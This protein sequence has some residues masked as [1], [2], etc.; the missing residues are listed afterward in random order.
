MSYSQWYSLLCRL[1][2]REPRVPKLKIRM[3]FRAAGIKISGAEIKIRGAG[4]DMRGMRI[5]IRRAGI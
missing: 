5:K 4:I 2:I 3:K 1:I